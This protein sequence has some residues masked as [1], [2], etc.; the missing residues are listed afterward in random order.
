MHGVGGP[1]C[2]SPPG[3]GPGK[4]GA[5]QVAAQIPG[6]GG[7]GQGAG[8]PQGGGQLVY[9]DPG[10]ERGQVARAPLMQGGNLE[11]GHAG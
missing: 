11:C 6:Q 2:G 4:A 10:Q 3:R 5:A 7:Q 8:K 1:D 9:R